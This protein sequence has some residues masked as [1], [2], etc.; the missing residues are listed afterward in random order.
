ML[1]LGGWVPGAAGVL[2]QAVQATVSIIFARRS[3]VTQYVQKLRVPARLSQPNLDPRDGWFLLFPQMDREDRPETLLELLNS[4]ST[5]VP[6][7]QDDDHSVLLLTRAGIDWVAVGAGVEGRLVLPP[8]HQTTHEQRV[9]L[10]FI[11]ES[12]VEA[13]VQWHGDPETARLSDHLNAPGGFFVAQTGF[14]TLIVNKVRVR[15]MRI[16]ESAEERRT[17]A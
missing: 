12:R 6:F 9:E 7:I 1:P 4:G 11:D 2:G 5:V 15:E 10:R 14:G 16:A 13:V 17:A 3:G 8:G